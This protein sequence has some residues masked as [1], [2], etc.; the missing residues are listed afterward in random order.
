MSQLFPFSIFVS[1]LYFCS[2][3]CLNILFFLFLFN[4]VSKLFD[5]FYFDVKTL[6]LFNQVFGLL[7]FIQSSAS[8]L[9]KGC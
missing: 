1:Q 9:I 4:Q 6:F 3:K 2:I 5:F 7:I 8:R